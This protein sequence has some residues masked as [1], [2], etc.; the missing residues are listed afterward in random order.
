MQRVNETFA[1]T[2]AMRILPL[3]LLAIACGGN[4]SRRDSAVERKATEPAQLRDAGVSGPRVPVESDVSTVGGSTGC[5]CF[6]WVHLD[7][8]GEQCYATKPVCD[9]E[10]D[11]FGRDM[12]IPCEM[13]A[14]CASYACRD[15][16]KE[17]MKL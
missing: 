14:T 8:N 2:R 12:K 17:C 10:F 5:Y 4:S 6:S 13:R 11:R 7:E 9:D 1:N 16:G 15:I 3:A